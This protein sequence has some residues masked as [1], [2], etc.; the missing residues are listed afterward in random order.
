M[1][2]I[3]LSVIPEEEERENEAEEILEDTLLRQ[4]LN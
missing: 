4:F 2:N 1:S 3:C